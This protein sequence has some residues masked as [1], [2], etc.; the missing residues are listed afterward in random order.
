VIY[1]HAV[2]IQANPHLWLLGR[3]SNCHALIMY[4]SPKVGIIHSS[5]H[6]F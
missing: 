1:K 2:I 6:G 4:L 3:L 5:E